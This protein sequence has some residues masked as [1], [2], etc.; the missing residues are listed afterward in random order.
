M[1]APP[2]PPN[3]FQQQLFSA[4]GGTNEQGMA[5]LPP[6]AA[7]D[8]ALSQLNA[9]GAQVVWNQRPVG[10]RFRLAKFSWYAGFKVKYEGSVNIAPSAPGQSQVSVNVRPLHSEMVVEWVCVG[11]VLVVFG[12]FCMNAYAMGPMAF[13]L[14]L[15]CGVGS[16]FI[17]SSKLPRDVARQVLQSIGTGPAMGAAYRPPQTQTVQTAPPPPPQPPKTPPVP[18]Q[19]APSPPPPPPP[20]AADAGQSEAVSVLKQLAHLREQELITQEEFD[21]KKREVL[22]KMLQ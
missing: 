19:R 8:A 13:V 9:L 18:E 15:I 11:A 21:A 1:N 22:N 5:G 16:Y 12:V 6:D 4:G 14:A 17:I 20:P 10:I 2:P 7:F 3:H